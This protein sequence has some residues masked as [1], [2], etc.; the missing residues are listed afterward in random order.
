M[1][2]RCSEYRHFR[3]K[4]AGRRLCVVLGR[5]DAFLRTAGQRA[6]RAAPG[7]RRQR[8]GSLMEGGPGCEAASRARA[9]NPQTTH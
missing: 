3:V 4:T 2:G 8:G 1:T 5:G 6:L 7:I 9:R